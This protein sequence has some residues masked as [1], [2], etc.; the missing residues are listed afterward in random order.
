[1]ILHRTQAIAVLYDLHNAEGRFCQSWV[2]AMPSRLWWNDDE[3]VANPPKYH[4]EDR[5]E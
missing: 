1:M 4:P 3:L 2:S 5:G